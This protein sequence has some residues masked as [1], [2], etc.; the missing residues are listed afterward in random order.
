[1][2]RL[3]RSILRSRAEKKGVKPSRYVAKMWNRY[4]VRKLG[5]AERDLNV[6]R[7]TKPKRLWP[8]R[9]SG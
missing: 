7:G 1:M 4:E 2:R 5:Q 3:M 9:V 8:G 6:R